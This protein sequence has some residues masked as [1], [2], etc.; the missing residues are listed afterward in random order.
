MPTQAELRSQ[1]TQQIISALEQGTIPWRRPW[2]TSP[3]AGRPT[4]VA[5][6]RP[7]QGINPLLLQLHAFRFGFQSKFW[8]TFDQWERWG[9]KVK[10]R[11]EGVEAGAWGAKVVLYKPV[12]KNVVDEAG[13]EGERSFVVM[14]TFTVFN[15]EQ[16]EGLVADKFLVKE[17]E[18]NAFPDFE[19]FEELIVATKADIRHGGEK[20]YYTRPLPVGTFPNHTDGDY[21]QV[22]EKHRFEGL[23]GYYETLAHELGHWCEVRLG[24]EGSYAMGELVAEMSSTYLCSELGVP[25]SGDLTNHASYLQSWIAAMEGDPKF[26]FQASTQAS[27]VTDLLLSLVRNEQPQPEH[28][29]V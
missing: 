4:S 23:A 7:Y 26:I 15:A 12:S 10:R 21:I 3:N 1:I 14:R 28:V 5:S 17:E 22:P 20:A 8:G 25:S 29:E 6:L 13:D 11:P 9:C 19:P 24:W 2:R 27:K 16:V 18:G